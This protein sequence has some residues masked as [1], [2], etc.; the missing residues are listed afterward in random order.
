MLDSGVEGLGRRIQS[1]SEDV[2]ATDT[3]QSAGPSDQ[4]EA[5]GPH[6]PEDVGVGAFARATPR[7]LS[8]RMRQP[9]LEFSE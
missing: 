6:A 2:A 1:E 3:G 4:Q 5:Q 8:T 9:G 7:S